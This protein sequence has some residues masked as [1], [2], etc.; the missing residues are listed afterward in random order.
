MTWSLDMMHEI[1]SGNADNRQK[2]NNFNDGTNLSENTFTKKMQT[3]N[4]QKSGRTK[5]Y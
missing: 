2:K 4:A 3:R 5:K 1:K